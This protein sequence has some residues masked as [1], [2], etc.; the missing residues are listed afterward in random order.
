M[1]APHLLAAPVVHLPVKARPTQ[2]VGPPPSPTCPKAPLAAHPAVDVPHTTHPS[3]SAA[4]EGHH[5]MAPPTVA[6]VPDPPPFRE[7]FTSTE[8]SFTDTSTAMRRCSSTP[9]AS[10]SAHHENDWPVVMADDMMYDQST[11]A[12]RTTAANAHESTPAQA[13]V[14]ALQLLEKRLR[15]SD[16]ARAQPGADASGPRIAKAGR[17]PG[18]VLAK[19]ATLANICQNSR[20]STC[21]CGTF[22]RIFLKK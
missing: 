3:A 18:K 21:N 19:F 2:A 8:N 6:H 7:G 15:A 17:N 12:Q 16:L 10:L 14:T 20:L 11:A 1:S 4:P 9:C 5:Q 22:C 13:A